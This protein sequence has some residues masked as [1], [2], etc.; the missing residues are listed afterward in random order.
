MSDNIAQIKATQ[1]KTEVTNKEIS[2]SRRVENIKTVTITEGNGTCPLPYVYSA[3]DSNSD[4]QYY[5]NGQ[6]SYSVPWGEDYIYNVLY[7][8][9]RK[10]I[11]LS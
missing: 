3:T 10:G 9:K 1:G 6:E 7:I 5:I 8:V 2:P 11:I 4:V